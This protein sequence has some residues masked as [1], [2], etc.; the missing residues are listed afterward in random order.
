MFKYTFVFSQSTSLQ[1]ELTMTTLAVSPETK[2]ADAV[3]AAAGTTIID[4]H[5]TKEATLPTGVPKMTHNCMEWTVKVIRSW[6][7][8]ETNCFC[9]IIS[10]AVTFFAALLATA[11]V[12]GIPFV[13]L[14]F[15]EHGVQKAEAHYMKYPVID[16]T[17]VSAEDHDDV[18]KK[19]EAAQKQLADAE[20]ALTIQKQA[21][22]DVR[23]QLDA[24]KASAGV[25][26]AEVTKL[27]ADLE[28]AQKAK[29]ELD[30][31]VATLISE[32]A[33]LDGQ[34]K[35]LQAQLNAHKA[36]TA[37]LQEQLG[38]A[39]SEVIALTGSLTTAQ[40]SLD[41]AKGEV[42]NLQAM[43][44]GSA[45]V[46]SNATKPLQDRIG[47]LTKDNTTKQAAI[48]KLNGE[49]TAANSAVT[50]LQAELETAQKLE[51]ATQEQVSVL[52]GQLFEANQALTASKQEAAQV[53][54]D[55]VAYK[56][57]QTKEDVKQ[58]G[59]LGALEGRAT[60]AE[61][62]FAAEKAE[63][64]NTAEQLRLVKEHDAK[65]SA[66][67]KSLSAK[68]ETATKVAEAN[69][70][71]ATRTAKL[72]Q[73]NARLSQEK[74]DLTK[75]LEGMKTQ[76]DLDAAVAAAKAGMKT[77]ADI[78]RAVNAAKTGLKT[79]AELDA[80]V[81]AATGD[82]EA[83]LKSTQA[84]LANAQVTLG[85]KASEVHQQNATLLKQVQ[86]RDGEVTKLKRVLADQIAKTEATEKSLGA[87][88]SELATKTQTA[89]LAAAAAPAPAKP[90]PETKAAATP[91]SDKKA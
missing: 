66:D 56:N 46:L 90:K 27:Q 17:A 88:R 13:W 36:S 64:A 74:A 72:A 10:W 28:E 41:L 83:Q 2:A 43:N 33:G 85:G 59:A 78:D 15:Q 51:T 62:Q 60:E 3:A 86:D 40:T 20:G 24:A 9:R 5:A 42:A 81:K 29:H 80:A 47:L 49:L 50:S 70:D 30:A 89:N 38:K 63:H 54:K 82:L 57:A 39:Q 65:L 19:L 58:L 77:Q 11:T 55:F 8:D 32:K 44:K 6:T 14:G 35:S 21:V 48:A 71:A 53:S 37:S 68:V 12:A 25:P 75:Q 23:G 69:K 91:A 18:T 87:A 79:Q 67:L 7:G 52:Q 4:V 76:A 34:A 1:G 16:E 84:L 31:R 26:A 45:D 73:E 22:I 61:T